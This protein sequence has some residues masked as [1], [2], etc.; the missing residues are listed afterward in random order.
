M[1]SLL[2]VP[3][4]KIRDKLISDVKQRITSIKNVLDKEIAFDDV[5]SSMKKGFE[6]EFDVELVEGT[7]TSGE[8]AMAKKIEKDRFLSKDWNHRR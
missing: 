1:F 7:L 5:A 4:E 6:E 2:I 8:T 3:S